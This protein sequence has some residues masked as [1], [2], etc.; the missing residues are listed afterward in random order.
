[1][2]ADT[3]LALPQVVHHEDPTRLGV[4]LDRVVNVPGKVL[5]DAR[6]A[7]GRRDHLPQHHIPVAEEAQRSVL[8]HS[9][10]EMSGSSCQFAFFS[11]PR[12]DK[13]KW[14]RH[15]NVQNLRVARKFRIRSGKN[16]WLQPQTGRAG[17]LGFRHIRWPPGRRRTAAND[18]AG[19]RL[20][21]APVRLC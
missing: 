15:T 21:F 10:L 16:L 11:R 4:G 8:W 12:A 13:T 1:M 17:S 19:G 2:S 7:N 14:P 20:V 18:V 5:F 3:D 9:H 6:G